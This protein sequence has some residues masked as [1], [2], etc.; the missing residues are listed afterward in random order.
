MNLPG[1]PPLAEAFAL[2]GKRIQEVHLHDNGGERDD[3]CWPGD[4]TVDWTAVREGL[5][6]LP[7]EVKG[8]LEVRFL[9]ETDAKTM[10]G[11]AVHCFGMLEAVPA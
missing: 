11:R 2:L 6:T 5:G 3:H 9:P 1:M 10:T 4:G 8:V 7:D